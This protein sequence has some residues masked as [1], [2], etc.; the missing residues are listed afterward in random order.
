MQELCVGKLHAELRVKALLVAKSAGVSLSIAHSEKDN[1]ATLK[2]CTGGIDLPAGRCAALRYLA[3]H[4][5]NHLYPRPPFAVEGLQNAAAID[6]WLDF[7]SSSIVE[8]TLA[9][10]AAGAAKVRPWGDNAENASSLIVINVRVRD[11]PPNIRSDILDVLN[12]LIE[13]F[14]L[15]EKYGSG[16][17]YNCGEMVVRDRMPRRRHSRCNRLLQYWTRT[18]LIGRLLPANVSAWRTW[19]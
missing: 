19:S 6:S 11:C 18:W 1:E 13:F 16:F 7:S 4:G 12:I 10:K 5:G 3:A 2:G 17:M 8:S 14:F 15:W 9:W